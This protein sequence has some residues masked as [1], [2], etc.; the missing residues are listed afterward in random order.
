MTGTA[1]VIGAGIGGL[2]AAVGL[3]AAGWDVEVRER[4]PA[5]PA[6]G[7]SLGLWPGGLHALDALGLGDTARERSR[8]A[9]DGRFVRAGGALIGNVDM[10]ALRRRTGEGVRVISRPA[11]LSALVDALDEGTVR[12]GEPVPDVRA[13]ASRYDV[14]V[15][16]DGLR[17]RARSVLFGGAHRPRYC[18]VTAWHG[19][20]DVDAP[21]MTETWGDSA[22]FGVTP[23]AGSRA[24][25]FACVRAPERAT[26]AGGELA[27]LR[28]RFGHWHTGVREI[29]DHLGEAPVHRND[30]YDLA[31]PLPAYVSGNIALIGDAAHAMTPDLGRGAC[32]ALTD[33][34]ALTRRLTA[35]TRVPQALTAYDAQRRPPTQRL[36]R[37]ARL[38]N[39][40]VHT[41]LPVTPARD[42]AMWLFLTAGRPPA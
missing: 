17:S 7:T 21:G 2:A 13:L 38:M 42:A 14:V 9:A 29:L 31:V 15:A 41:R 12:Y 16:A 20:A 35:R 18:G 36:A 26:P 27:A 32:E 23:R 5:P 3:R 22:R 1:I 19:T 40:A 24:N 6:T 33:A 11:L 30:L 10:A 8:A 25:W 37:A 34:V 39:R 28:R 4:A